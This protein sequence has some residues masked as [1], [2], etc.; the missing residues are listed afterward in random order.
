MEKFTDTFRKKIIEYRKCL[1]NVLSSFTIFRRTLTGNH[2]ESATFLK[3]SLKMLRGGSCGP[4]AHIP[5]S[6]FTKSKNPGGL[7]VAEAESVAKLEKCVS[8]TT[9]ETRYWRS[10][11]RPQTWLFASTV[12]SAEK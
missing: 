6:D 3:L 11:I 12:S 4:A 10:E 8:K 5:N 1:G 7:N 9:E 2:G